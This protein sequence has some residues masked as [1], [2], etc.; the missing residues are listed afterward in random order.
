[1]IT[2]L[3]RKTIDYLGKFSTKSDILRISRPKVFSTFFKKGLT[4]IIIYDIIISEE[5]KQKKIRTHGG[6]AIF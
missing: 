6:D 1:M 5:G 4:F 3:H 2:Y